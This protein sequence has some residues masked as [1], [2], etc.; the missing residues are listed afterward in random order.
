MV[1]PPARTAVARFQLRDDRGVTIESPIRVCL[2]RQLETQCLEHEPHSVPVTLQD[3]DSLTA[4]GPDHGPVHIN[5]RDLRLTTGGEF[6]VSVPRKAYL[7]V[8]N[9]PDQALTLSLYNS[10]DDTYRKPAFRFERVTANSYRIPAQNFLVSLSHGSDAPDLQVVRARPGRRYPLAYHRRDGWSAVIRC[11]SGDSKKPLAGALTTLL[12]TS[13][14][15]TERELARGVSGLDGLSVLVGITEPF[16]SLSTSADGYMRIRTPG[17]V[18]GRGT[19]TFREVLLERGG[20]IRALV[21]IDGQP[22]TGALCQLVSTRSKRRDGERLPKGEVYFERR[23]AK[24]GSCVTARVARGEYILRVIPADARSSNDQLVTVIEG[25]TSS[26]EVALRRIEVRGTV[27]RGD[28]P[29]PGAIVL[30]GNDEDNAKSPSGRTTPPQPLTAETDEE[31]HYSGFVWRKG[32]YAFLVTDKSDV[33]GPAKFGVWIG[34]QGAVVDFQLNESS[35]SGIVIDQD[36]KPLAGAWANLVVDNPSVGVVSEYRKQQTK[37][38]GRFLY[39]LSGGGTVHVITSK[40][41]YKSADPIDLTVTPESSIP[42]LTIVLKQLDSLEGRVLT[43]TGTPAVGVTVATYL[44]G[45]GQNP[46]RSGDGITDSEG[47]FVVPKAPA[48]VT[49]VFLS[50]S[51]CPLQIVDVANDVGEQTLACAD[52][53][54]SLEIGMK[55]LAGKPVQDE[56]VFLRWNGRL[57]PRQVLLSHLTLLG[58][59]FATGGAGKLTIVGL[60]PGDYDVFLGSGASEATI[61]HGEKHGF[62]GSVHLDPFAAAEIEALVQF[63]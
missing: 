11:L 10:D 40:K 17:V 29:E 7:V 9:V 36:G 16:A 56:W 23:L 42:P 5:R 37:E 48:P 22:A 31:G 63:N 21:T 52:T 33:P 46:I 61:S 32:T 59:P 43:G 1:E 3:F 8:T 2:Y 19:F 58:L 34:E 62:L 12:S 27:T 49:R 51:G 6:P 50:G 54:S 44:A 47:H 15:E 20:D 24:D 35:I 53:S 18:A 26:M 25:Q 57:L 39:P 38:D 13:I 30:I 45:T 55:T 4:E 14:A 60:P 28:R 41:G